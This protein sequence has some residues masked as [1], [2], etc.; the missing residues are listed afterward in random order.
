MK[1]KLSVALFSRTAVRSYTAVVSTASRGIGLEF[2]RQLLA[3]PDTRVFAVIRSEHPGADLKSLVDIYADRVVI[4]PNVDLTDPQ[5]IQTGIDKINAV[6]QGDANSSSSTASID[7]LINSAG[8][9]GNNS[10]EQPGPERSVLKVDPA[11]LMQ[12]MQVNFM[13]HVLMTQG[14]APLMK[15]R[16]AKDQPATS[17]N[18]GKIINLSARVGSIEDNALGGWLSYRCSKTALNQFTRTA[19]I[20]LKRNNCAVI[21]LHPGTCDTDMSQIFKKGLK[22]GQLMSTDVA[23]AKMLTVIDGLDLDAAGGYYAYDGKTIAW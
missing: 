8:I 4:V 19:A 16:F 3:R 6:C 20:E 1:T 7:L 21:S 18:I 11:W 14:V 2:T 15:R 22:P 13:A 5:S 9:L 23:C 12:T 10:T 17:Q